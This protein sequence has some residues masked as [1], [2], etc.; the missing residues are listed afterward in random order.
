VWHEFQLLRE[1]VQEVHAGQVQEQQ[2]RLPLRW[3]SQLLR[4]HDWN[5]RSEFSSAGNAGSVWVRT[6]GAGKQAKRWLFRSVLRDV[7]ALLWRAKPPKHACVLTAVLCVRLWYGRHNP[8][9]LVKRDDGQ[10]FKLGKSDS[11]KYKKPE[12]TVSEFLKKKSAKKGGLGALWWKMTK[13]NPDH[14][15]WMISGPNALSEE[16]CKVVWAPNV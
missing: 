1:A 14:I 2:G 13:A 3:D 12:M 15:Q 16:Q 6:E 5:V 11:E 10:Y 9:K 8:D 7:R 4:E